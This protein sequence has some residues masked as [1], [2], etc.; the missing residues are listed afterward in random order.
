MEGSGLSD[1]LLES[2]LISIGSIH[3]VLSGKNYSRSIM[4]HKVLFESLHRLLLKKYVS[5]NFEHLQLMEDN[6]VILSSGTNAEFQ[7][8]V[9]D[10]SKCSIAEDYLR[11][12]QQTREGG[13]GKTAKLCSI[14]SWYYRWIFG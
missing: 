14:L 1:V 9:S 11:F 2:N 13:L 3:G 8:I 10:L 7:E 6:E 4:C 5:E 12:C